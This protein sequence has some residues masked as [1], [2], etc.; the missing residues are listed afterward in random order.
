[1]QYSALAPAPIGTGEPQ[2]RPVGTP[3]PAPGP[4]SPY[5]PIFNP[6]ISKTDPSAMAA[7]MQ[8]Q[9]HT[10]TVHH[11]LISAAA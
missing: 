3:R 4:L 2:A 10:L 9:V 8:T 7:N 11:N 5:N 6:I 1:M